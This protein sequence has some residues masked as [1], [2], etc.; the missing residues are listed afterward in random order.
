MELTNPKIKQAYHGGCSAD[1]NGQVPVSDFNSVVKAFGKELR[2]EYN[3]NAKA[4][5]LNA[6]LN[7]GLVR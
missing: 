1:L 5:V 6:A 3:N 7:G 2:D 4:A